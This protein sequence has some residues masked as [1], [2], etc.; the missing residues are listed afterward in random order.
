MLSYIQKETTKCEACIIGK[1]KRD[2]FTTSTWQSTIYLKLIHS[3]IC[4]SMESYFGGCKYFIIFIDDFTRMIWVY[5]L[6][7]K[8]EAFE[9]LI[10][11]QRLVKNVSN[12][13]IATLRIDNGG[14]FTSNEFNN[15][16]KKNGIKKKLANSY[17]KWQNGVI[18]IM[19][20]TLIGM[21]RSILQFKG[22]STKYWAES[23]HTKVYLRKQ[24]PK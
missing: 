5:F 4:G 23:V 24:S 10:H 18:K 7:V 22:L 2:H 12:D 14:E 6:K 20:G 3:D 1:Q 17:T 8:L 21:E 9:K 15:Y 19:N 11:F 16:S 13:K